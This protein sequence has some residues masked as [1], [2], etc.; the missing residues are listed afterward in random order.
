MLVDDGRV[1]AR[2]RA[3][4]GDAEVVEDL[5]GKWLLPAFVDA[6]CHILP[7]G[8]DLQKLH[9]GT[10]TTHEQVLDLVRDRHRSDPEGWLLAVHYDQNLYPEGRHLTSFELDAVSS[11]RPILLRH[12]NGHAS[13]ANS[14]ALRAAGVLEDVADPAGGAFGRDEFGRLNGLLLENAH[15]YVWDRAPAPT[16]EEMTDAILRA[17]ER[18][19]EFGIGCASDMMTGRFDLRQELLAYRQAA[20]RGCR[21]ATRLYVQWG[22]ALGPRGLPAHEFVE[23]ADEVG[24][25]GGRGSGVAGV[26]IFADGAIGSATAAIYGRYSGEPANGPVLSRHSRAASEG[27]DAEVAGQLIYRPER[28]TEMTRI[29]HDAGWPVAVHA[30]GDYASDLVMDAFAAT[31]EPSRHRLEHGMILSDAQIARMA[32]LGCSLTFQP[33]FLLRFGH[34]YRRQLGEARAYR[35]KRSRSVIDAGIPLSFSSDRPIVGGNP[36]DGM[37]M[38]VGRPGFDPAERCTAVEALEAYTVAGSRVN[39]D[40][41]EFGSL[42]PGTDAAFQVLDFDP[43]EAVSGA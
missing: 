25:A 19:W 17:G 39:G 10:A 9:L 35:L 21:V 11:T 42:L 13:I 5:Q 33:E 26:K 41:V 3:V 12:V 7:T 2:D 18:M 24:R 28:L 4:A 20:D 36:W 37:R 34:S 23:L 30:I 38:A 27:A 1:V 43:R 6:H 40:L 22:A 31:G 32:S 14:A 29:A 16:L 8:L 15:E